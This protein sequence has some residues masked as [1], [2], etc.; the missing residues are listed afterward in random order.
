VLLNTFNEK[1]MS[2][3]L[4]KIIH[5]IREL[6]KEAFFYKKTGS[7]GIIA[8]VNAVRQYPIAQINLAL[9]QMVTD[10]NEYVNDKYGRLG[11]IINVGDYYL[12]QPIELTDTRISIYERSTPVP[13]KHTAIQ[14]PLP[15]NITE[16][17]L[18]IIPKSSVPGTGNIVPNKQVV[19]I[20]TT[21]SKVA[22]DEPPIETDDVAVAS[23]AP[24]TTGSS[25][26]GNSMNTETLAENIIITLSNRFDTCNTVYDKPTK[27]QDEMY[28]YCGKVIRQITN[29]Q[30]F[31]TS[32]EELH[33]H[34]IA[35]LLEH[36]SFEDS[37]T[38]LN[39]L[40]HKND[41]SMTVD[42]QQGATG[43]D[44]MRLQRLPHF[45]R[46]LLKYYSQQVLHRPLIGRRAVAA[47][48][49]SGAAA[50]NLE[51]K[52]MLLFN[53]NKKNLYELIVLRYETHEWSIA[54][55][56]DLREFKPI[57]D[58][59]QTEQIRQMNMIVGFISLF[60]MEYLVF[61]VKIMSKKRDKGARCDQ[62]GKS[63]AISVIN[64]VLSMNP[65]TQGDEY[66]LTTEN[67][68]QRTQ[69]ELC[70]FQEFILRIFDRKSINGRKWFFTPCEALLCDIEGYHI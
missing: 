1:F 51:D 22:V 49:A 47:T 6:Y 64:T 24:V 18:G 69:R 57:L 19:D 33:E 44:V 38:L 26:S 55:P 62:S 10:T 66:I 14:Y 58:K 8:R 23:A 35:H 67:T 53:K 2:M 20:L 34:I 16:D 27:E 41:S 68:K 50:K 39:Y 7:N 43:G 21:N 36:L 5:K 9:T 30:E 29:S 11:R 15:E 13:Y 61:K 54:E 32:I 17:Y 59:V 42:I 45:E 12:F 48:A 70:V 31:G 28:Y 52:G 3:N 56:E 46:M 63:D 25:F 4:D 40:Y 65:E 60:K 37:M